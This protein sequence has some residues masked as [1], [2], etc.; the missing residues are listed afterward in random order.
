[1][2]LHGF[3]LYRI[4]HW[5]ETVS[6]HLVHRAS[7][8]SCQFVILLSPVFTQSFLIPSSKRCLSRFQ[9]LPRPCNVAALTSAQTTF[10]ISS[11]ASKKVQQHIDKMFINWVA[12]SFLLGYGCAINVSTNASPW[13]Q[14]NEPGLIKT[15][16]TRFFPVGLI[17]CFLMGADLFTS[18]CLVNS[19]PYVRLQFING[20]KYPVVALLDHR[21]TILDIVKTWS[22]SFW[23]ICLGCFSSPL[24]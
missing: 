18:Y 3:H 7:D 13:F 2:Y 9:P 17:M 16:S 20:S 14:D 6:L 12:G 21:I 19:V 8:L 15:I 10:F 4:A 11:I 24:S 22:V 5:Q 23:A 1:M